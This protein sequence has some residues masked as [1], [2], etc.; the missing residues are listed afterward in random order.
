MNFARKKKSGDLRSPDFY[1]A[2]TGH[3]A[4]A[5][6][7]APTISFFSDSHDKDEQYKAGKQA[8]G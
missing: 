4:L 7:T 2:I 8:T 5:L 1:P 6:T 3:I